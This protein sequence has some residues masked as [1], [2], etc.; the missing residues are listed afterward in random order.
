MRDKLA[1]ESSLSIVK[2]IKIIQYIFQKE[3]RW[4]LL[5][6]FGGKYNTLKDVLFLEQ[7]ASV[8]SETYFTFFSPKLL[9]KH[10]CTCT[11][12][13]QPGTVNEI[14]WKTPYRLI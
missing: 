2:K 14:I 13:S 5:K 3:H 7:S 8:L 9:S 4:E 11:Y 1:M 6:N 10:L 12:V